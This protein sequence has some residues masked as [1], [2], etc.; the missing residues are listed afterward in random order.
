M[1]TCKITKKTLSQILLHAFCLHF[2]RIHTITFYEDALKVCK[3]N[4]S[5]EML[6]ESISLPIQ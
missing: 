5:Q 6:A 4:F 3:H 1:P 2:L